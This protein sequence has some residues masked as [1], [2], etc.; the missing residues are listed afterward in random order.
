MKLKRNLLTLAVASVLVSGMHSVHAADAPAPDQQ[1]STTPGTDDAAKKKEDSSAELGT[2]TVTGVRAA[3]ERAISVKQ[4]SNE[5]VEVISA[6]D[7]GKLPDN[8][9]AESLARLPGLAAQRVAGRASTVSLRGFSG[10]FSGTLLNGREQVSTGDNRAIEFDQYPSELLSGV[11]VYKT[12]EASL[13]GQGIAG[14]IAMQSVR[15]LDYNK[16]TV[17][18]GARGEALSNSSVN[19]NTD[20]KGYRLN[21]SY[22]DQYLDHTLGLAIGY[23]RLQ[24]PTQDTRWESWGY[25]GVTVPAGTPGMTAG[26][27]V[28]AL[29]GTKVYADSTEGTRD[30]LMTTVEWRPNEQ[31]TSTLDLYYSKFNQKLVYGGFEA[32]L[33]WGNGT[34]LSNPVV[35]NGQLVGGTWAK[36]KP[37]LREEVDHHDDKIRS[38]GWNNKLRFGDGWEASADLSYGKANSS[39]SLMEEYA[40]TPKNGGATDTWNFSVDPSTGLPHFGVGLNYADPN[41]IKLTDSG[42]WGQ[43]GYLK[44]PKTS[45]ELKAARVDLSRE[46]NSPISKAAVGINYNERTKSRHSDEYFMSLP[47]SSQGHT[48]VAVS[49]PSSCLTSSTF[50]GYVGF[51]SIVSWDPDCAYHQTY[52]LQQFTHKD[53]YNKDWTVNEKVGT[54]YLK[55]DIDTEVAG[56]PLRGNVG[57]QYVHVKQHADAT[58]TTE[59]SGSVVANP[60]HAGTSYSNFLPSLNLVL[61]MPQDNYLRFGAGREI[62]R[63]R[64]DYMRANFD[65]GINTQ[66]SGSINVFPCTESSGIVHP[67]CRIE[68][69]GG[70]PKL[71]PFL[72]DAYDLSYEKYWET[73]AYVSAT[74]F[75]KSLKSYVY[76]QNVLFDY[77]GLPT[78]SF[79][80]I[81]PGSYQGIASVPQNGT[82]GYMRGYELTASM[83]LDILWEPLEGFGVLASY[84]NTHSSICPGGPGSCGPFPGLSK[85]VSQATVYYE[86]AGFSVRMAATHR[87]SYLGEVQAFGADR[88]LHPIDKETV[89]DF[90]LGYT[91][92]SGNYEGLN[93][94]LQV[95]NLF[96][97]PYRESYGPG[98]P[99]QYT[100]YGRRVLLG[101]NYKF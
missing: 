50:L 11:V 74:Y 20:S 30:A 3:I 91:I 9:I 4:N 71:K 39:Q 80:G 14:T 22:I 95:Q 2:I 54:A 61:T 33:P 18:V 88:E 45:D 59:A 32:G 66:S 19:A 81:V 67:H 21:A 41:L 40:G 87:S 98:Q 25:T 94:L 46:I 89:A 29:G 35:S 85:Y 55:F 6:E 17:Q 36:V 53:I 78:S 37:V 90:Q 65:Y 7:I 92:P 73:K 1:T 68:G 97:E 10:D 93:F 52:S 100:V 43:D 15:P 70:N 51:P 5:I 38:I 76:N 44:F 49:V 62:A 48:G 99:R 24:S 34:V 56:M 23:A 86:K 82:G 96:N 26:G 13:V 60:V 77:T 84:A 28:Q 47:G 12:P 27:T 63:P 42:G 69:S 64:M 79:N 83:P 58:A 8:S 31:F 16:R 75:F 101:V 72:A 57:A